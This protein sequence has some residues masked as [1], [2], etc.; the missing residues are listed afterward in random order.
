VVMKSI[1]F[2][3]MAPCSLLSFNRRFGGTYRLHF[4]V[5]EIIL[6]EPASKQVASGG[7]GGGGSSSS[8]LKVRDV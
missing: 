4:R 8:R 1:I 2:G 7:G 6:Q 5:E 3:D